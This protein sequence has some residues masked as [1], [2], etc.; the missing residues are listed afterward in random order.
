MRI[1]VKEEQ[2]RKDEQRKKIESI[3]KTS[4]NNAF[5]SLAT[6]KELD[7]GRSQSKDTS[8]TM[9]NFSEYIEMNPSKQSNLSQDKNIKKS[10]FASKKED[11]DDLSDNGTI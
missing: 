3:N 2:R 7:T 8:K 4:T 10:G 5:L 11:S 1:D 9:N 6:F